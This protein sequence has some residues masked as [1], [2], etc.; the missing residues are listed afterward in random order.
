MIVGA[1]FLDER[2][3]IMN[4]FLTS[5][6]DDV[7]KLYTGIKVT[8]E[9]GS[10]RLYKVVLLA[11]ILDVIAKAMVQFFKQFNATAADEDSSGGCSRCEDTADRPVRTFTTD[12]NLPRKV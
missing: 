12:T 1:L 6:V 4:S 5:W 7:K 8:L 3:P 10:Q 2:K 9:D 11:G